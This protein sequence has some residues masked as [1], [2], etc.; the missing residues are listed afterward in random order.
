MA[1]CSL[2]PDRSDRPD[3]SNYSQFLKYWPEQVL[4]GCRQWLIHPHNGHFGASDELL[5]TTL[6]RSSEVNYSMIQ[7]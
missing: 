2:F 7:Q 1:G 3:W 5:L 6:G 4:K